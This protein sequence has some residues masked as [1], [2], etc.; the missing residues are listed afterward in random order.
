MPTQPIPKVSDADVERI[1]R[2]DFG[3][4]LADRV[5]SEL[6]RY[7]PTNGPERPRVRVDILRLAGGDIERLSGGV[8][9]AI[10]DY[11]DVIVGAE[12]PNYP[13]RMKD[14]ILAQQII[15]RDWRG[16]RA[17]FESTAPNQS[18]EPTPSAVT[19]P[20]GQESRPR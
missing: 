14:D 1:A 17:W 19:S 13:Y 16:Y 11:R 10:Q 15:D 6:S 8:A 9:L 18:S 3:A 7:G 20:A 12:M 4:N 2:R 5:I